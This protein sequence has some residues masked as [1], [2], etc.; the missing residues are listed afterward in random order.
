LFASTAAKLYH[1]LGRN[2][3][4]AG[5]AVHFEDVT[6]KSGLGGLPG[7]GLGVVSID[8][9]GD[10]WPDIFAAN[11]AMANFLWVNQHDGT[12]RE[13]A[14]RRGVALNALGQAQG[15][16]G[17]GLGDMDGDGLLDLFVTHLTS[18]IHTLWRQTAPGL[19]QDQTGPAGLANS[20]WRGTGFGT[21]FGD[22]DHDGALDLAIVNGRVQASQEKNTDPTLG[23]FW[24]RYA[25]CNQLFVNNGAG[26][27]RDISGVNAPFCGAARVSRG[28]ACGDI[29]GDGALDLL[30]TTVGGP[31]RLYRNVTPK[32][33]H[34]L[35]VRLIDPVLR[36]DAYGARVRVQAGDHCCVGIVS[37]GQSY[38]CSCDRRVH[39]GLGQ[40]THVDAITVDWPDGS[41]ELFPGMAVDSSVLLRKGE[42]KPFRGG[43]K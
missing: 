7:K 5:Q 16:M 43:Q 41:Q 11:D 3:D 28:L 37:P 1:N 8:L 17:I 36:R 22:F 29:D 6:T 26:H 27:F 40:A 13:E 34:W 2:A 32:R 10:G 4:A 35:L 18:E 30:V 23:P 24:S 33:G 25:E 15:N 39:F 12:F 42:G 19:F 21:V 20:Q 31:A 9:T 38:L 14:V